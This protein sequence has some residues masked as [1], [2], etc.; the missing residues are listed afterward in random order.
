MRIGGQPTVA[1]GADRPQATPGCEDRSWP[2]SASLPRLPARSVDTV[3]AVYH[4]Q[5]GRSSLDLL[6]TLCPACEA[7]KT[8]DE[9]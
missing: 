8:R 9:T 7:V 3:L 4:G 6:V 2:G 5:P 1:G